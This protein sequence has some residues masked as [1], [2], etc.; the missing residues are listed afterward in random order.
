MDEPDIG[1][2]V[3][4]AV[5]QASNVSPSAVTA[6]SRLLDLNLDSLALVSVLAQFEAV[7]D[8]ELHPDEILSMLEASTVAEII[9]LLKERLG[10]RD[11]AGGG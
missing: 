9:A 10:P 2:L 5:A 3:C 1:E 8:V 7:Y 6:E 11:D 4:S